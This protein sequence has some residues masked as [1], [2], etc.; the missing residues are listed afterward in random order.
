[1]D[2]SLDN[3]FFNN[4]NEGKPF[5]RRDYQHIV[6]KAKYKRDV[7]GFGSQRDFEEAGFYIRNSLFPKLTEELKMDHD[8]RVATYRYL[9]LKDPLFMDREEKLEK[10]ESEA[11]LLPEEDAI[12][13]GEK[14]RHIPS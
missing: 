7:I 13:I 10:H 2:Q 12:V 11:Y 6:R 3:I 1:M 14:K 9:L 8:T 5:S 4:D